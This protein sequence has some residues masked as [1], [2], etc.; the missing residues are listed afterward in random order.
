MK[1]NLLLLFILVL[2]CA[3]AQ[4]KLSENQKLAAT[5]KVWGFLKYY[6]PLVANGSKNWD[7][8]LFAILPVVE[9]AQSKEEFS[10]V[11]ENWI[12]Q[13]GEIKTY[14]PAKPDPAIEYFTKNLDLSWT[15]DTKVF[16]KALS[17]KL[18]LIQN[19]RYQ[20]NQYYIDYQSDL[21]K[22]EI[23]YPDFK[24]SNKNLRLLA[25]FRY[26]NL[27][28]Y[29]FP[30]KYQMD[31]KWDVTLE[32]MM[33]R[34]SSSE[35]ETDYNLALRE[36][37]VKLND[38]HTSFDTMK[39]HE[40]LGLKFTPIIFK[41]VDEKIIVIDFYDVNLAAANDLKFGDVITKIDGK[42]INELI[43][44]KKKYI[45]GSNTASMLDNFQ[46]VLL[47]GNS[48]TI[49][50]ELTRDGV[51]TTKIINRYPIG[52]ITISKEKNLKPEWELLQGNVGYVNIEKLSVS[53]LPKIMEE[54]KNTKA[55]IF[56]VRGYPKDILLSLAEYLNPSEKQ[57]AR[58]IV[59]DLTYPGRF[60]WAATQTCGKQNPDYYKG[61]VI[62]LV[63]EKTFSQS[64]YLTMVL[65]TSPNHT[66]IGSQTAGADGS[67]IR[68]Q[69]IK[70]FRTS[71]S[72]YGVFYPNKKETQRIGIVPDIIVKP[73]ILGIQQGK[74]E[75]LDRAILFAGDTRTN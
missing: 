31:Q 6:H 58:Q 48:D 28:E 73:T 46:Y 36:L 40:Y 75:I 60:Y 54:F 59:P 4:N 47:N 30:Y 21:L 53:N 69:I 11:L 1:K 44:E 37:T 9:K 32:G 50:V 14:A 10:L 8:Q 29:F 39:V 33:P 52:K 42:N 26:W 2:H 5:C 17:K 34:F 49:S 18:L 24:W 23:Q 43:N 64:E 66:T 22:N 41:I 16:S 25:F 56:D 57:Y 19:N 55:I 71:F 13:Q 45:S 35:S 3:Y 67:N 51:T 38:R 74:D 20:A 7:E 12:A 27:V 68:F 63:N 70:G 61:K 62:S 65:Q 72:G 15:N